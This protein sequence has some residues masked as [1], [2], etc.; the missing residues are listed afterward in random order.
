MSTVYLSGPITG[1]TYHDARYGWRKDFS[2]RLDPG[3]YVLSPMRH[4][5]HLAEIKGPLSSNYPSHLFSHGKMIVA[6]DF[7]DIDRSD[8]VVANFLGSEK[9]SRGTLVELGYA[10]AKGKTIVAIVEK[11]NIHYYPFVTELAAVVVEDIQ[12]AAT[13]V[14]SLLSVGL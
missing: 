6:K 12:T 10:H 8:L 4:E 5:G 7:L 14:N 1:L 2:N 9:V 3:V 11:D 13:I